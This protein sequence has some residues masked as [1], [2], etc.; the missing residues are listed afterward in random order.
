MQMACTSL[1]INTKHFFVY[2]CIDDLNIQW[3]YTR[4][5]YHANKANKVNKKTINETKMVL[6]VIRQK[7]Q[8]KE[9]KDTQ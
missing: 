4:T 2:L 3:D 5:M 7:Y 1:N 9:S 8:R 6:Q